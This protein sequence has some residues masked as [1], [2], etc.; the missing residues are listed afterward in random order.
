MRNVAEFLIGDVLRSH[1]KEELRGDRAIGHSEAGR[2]LAR[3]A[4]G[5]SGHDELPIQN[6]SAAGVLNIEEGF[7]TQLKDSVARQAHVEGAVVGVPSEAPRSQAV[8]DRRIKAYILDIVQEVAY[9]VSLLRKA[10]P[11]SDG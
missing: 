4:H 5:T 6:D 10:Q 9:P 2:D 8:A 11:G 3:G 7:L 1:P